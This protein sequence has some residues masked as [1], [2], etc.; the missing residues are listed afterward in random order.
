MAS[1]IE[2]LIDVLEKENTEYEELLKLSNE[3]TGIIIRD[4]INA[5]NEMIEKEQ[6]HLD[7]IVNYENKRIEITGDMAV[8]LNKD[9]STLTVK[10]I[11]ELLS[12][13]EKEQERLSLI[14]DRLKK[15]LAR[16]QT[17]NETNKGLIEESLE[18][19]DFNINYLNGLSQVP[20]TANYNKN[21]YNQ[22]SGMGISRF[23]AKN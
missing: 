8:V 23:D 17:V 20:E 1:L 3:K 9:V 7:R 18:L 22:D 19:I 5:M 2:E 16:V 11:V 21:A 4:D 10:G 15:T 13:Q 14:H 12:G 6:V